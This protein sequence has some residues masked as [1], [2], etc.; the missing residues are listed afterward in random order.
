MNEC[1]SC[2]VAPA[3]SATVIYCEDCIEAMAERYRC[4]YRDDVPC[5]L[6]GVC[7]ADAE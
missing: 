4:C 2:Q 7:D 6:D 3:I 1:T 5:V